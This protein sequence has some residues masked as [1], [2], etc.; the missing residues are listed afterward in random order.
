MYWPPQYSSCY[1]RSPYVPCTPCAVTPVIPVPILYPHSPY[2]NCAFPDRR[3]CDPTTP[4][5]PN[6]GLAPNSPWN[7]R[8]RECRPPSWQIFNTHFWPYPNTAGVW[9][10]CNYQPSYCWPGVVSTTNR[11]RPFCINR[12]INAELQCADFF[13]DLSFPT[14]KPIQLYGLGQSGPFPE[15][16]LMQFATNPPLTHLKIVFDDLPECPCYIQQDPMCPI[17]LKDVLFKI[18]C[19]V[20]TPITMT[21]FACLNPRAQAQVSNAFTERCQAIPINCTA[22]R[23]SGVKRVDYLLGKTRLVGLLHQGHKDGWEVMRV[24]VE[25]IA[26][27]GLTRS[28]YSYPRWDYLCG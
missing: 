22:E 19:H 9:P 17:T 21:D 28:C 7:V 8:R 3:G 5:T 24:V 13:F 12:W 16:E 18:H 11:L 15:Q 2:S 27:S 14:F 20:H 6:T 4:N 23:A 26:P 25:R 1:Q 10:H